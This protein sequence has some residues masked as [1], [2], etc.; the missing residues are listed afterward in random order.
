MSHFFIRFYLWHANSDFSQSIIF[1]KTDITEFTCETSLKYTWMMG[2]QGI[3]T[4][5]VFVKTFPPTSLFW[6]H[7]WNPVWLRLWWRHTMKWKPTP[8]LLSDFVGR[9]FGQKPYQSVYSSKRAIRTIIEK[10]QW[11]VMQTSIQNS[12]TFDTTMFLRIFWILSLFFS[13]NAIS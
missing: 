9:F 1:Q 4:S 3:S 6:D 10:L 7:F 12:Q 11:R 5:A 13:L 2:L 8:L